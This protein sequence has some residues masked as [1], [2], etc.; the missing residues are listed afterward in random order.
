MCGYEQALALAW[1]FA[2]HVASVGGEIEVRAEEYELNY[3]IKAKL[4][5]GKKAA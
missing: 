5:E 2:A 3:D 1:T 4:F